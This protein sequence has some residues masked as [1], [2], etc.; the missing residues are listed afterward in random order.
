[1]DVI[2]AERR[3]VELARR[4]AFVEHVAAQRYDVVE[5]DSP[6]TDLAELS[7]A[8][9]RFIQ[10]MGMGE[11]AW[12]PMPR[13]VTDVLLQAL[14]GR[15]WHISVR[16]AFGRG[17]KV[18]QP[19]DEDGAED[20][21]GQYPLCIA[22]IGVRTPACVAQWLAARAGAW[23]YAKDRKR[24]PFGFFDGLSSSRMEPDAEQLRLWLTDACVN[25]RRVTTKAIIEA[26]EKVWEPAIT[27]FGRALEGE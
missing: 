23:R 4:R 24:D 13:A 2:G 16:F 1:M 9:D 7:R 22:S 14:D 26:A 27:A 18:F 11:F 6:Y 20:K 15:D 12:P 5:G 17:A 19:P 8:H 21:V 25:N 10:K 3:L